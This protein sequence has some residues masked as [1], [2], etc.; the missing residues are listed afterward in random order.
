MIRIH[1]PLP[2]KSVRKDRLLFKRSLVASSYDIRIH[3]PLLFSGQPSLSMPPFGDAHLPWRAIPG[4]MRNR[5]QFSCERLSK[6]KMETLSSIS[7]GTEFVYCFSVW[8]SP[9]L[10][11]YQLPIMAGPRS[12]PRHLGWRY[13]DIRI[14]IRK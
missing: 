5:Y 3:S 11:N 2:D 6:M 8:V 1:S 14:F 12:L 10:S 13:S 9:F 4:C 7:V